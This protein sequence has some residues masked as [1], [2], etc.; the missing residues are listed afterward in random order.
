[1]SLPLG[2]RLGV[3]EVLHKLG[4]GGMG[5]VYKA[6][7][8]RL[9]RLVA[10]KILGAQMAGPE[11]L[12]RFEQE[13]RAA[14]ALNHPNILT[15]YDVGRE[16]EVVYFAMEW[17]EGQTLRQLMASGPLPLARALA[18][19]QQAAEGLAKAHAAGVVHRDLKPENVMVSADGYA[20]IVD[21]GLAKFVQGA[22]SDAATL[23]AGT[24][25]GLVMGSAGYMSPEQARGGAVDYR[26]DQFALGLLIYEMV[27]GVRPFARPTLTQTLAATIDE[28]PEPIERRAPAVSEHLAAVV[29]RC[30][31]KQP[32]ERYESTRDL[33]R[34]LKAILDTQSRGHRVAAPSVAAL[35]VAA[36]AVAAP[37]RV[38]LVAAAAAAVLIVAAV[39]AAVW[40]PAAPAAPE[41]TGHPIVAVQAFQNLS[42]DASQGYFA[43]GMT[44]E[45]RGQLSKVGA[46]RLLSRSAVD[47]Y[48]GDH[49]R[50]VRELGVGSVVEGTVRVEGTRVRIGATLIDAATQ[51]TL[52]SEQYDRDLADV[53]AVQS[54]VALRI[55]Q[56]LHAN[57]SADERAR[58]ERRPTD[59]LEAYQLYLKARQI[60]SASRDGNV[61]SIALMRQAL[62]LDP[63]FALARAAM[64]YRMGFLG[65]GDATWWPNALEEAEAAV[66]T[67]PSLPTAHF[68]LA[69]VYSA[70]GRPAQARMSFLRALEIDPSHTGSMNNL[71]VH[72]WNFGRSD[73]SLHW[74][75]RAFALSDKQGNSFYH[76][77]I[78]LTT[79]DLDALREWL[80]YAERFA[81][82]H[83]RVQLTFATLE[84]LEGRAAEARS[85]VEAARATWPHNEEV[86]MAAADVAFLT[87]R[88]DAPALFE[89]LMHRPELSWTVLQSV[90]LRVAY[91]AARG[92]DAARAAELLAGA[93]RIARQRLE[94]GDESALPPLEIAGVAAVRGERDAAL[95]WLSRAFDAGH[96]DY[97]VL[98]RNPIFAPVSADPRFTALV[99]RMRADV[100]AQQARARERG[101]LDFAP[102]LPQ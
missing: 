62:A 102:L 50:M 6:R 72:E 98:E 90:R 9:D 94:A 54:D 8:T 1:M 12:H 68:A 99:A 64:A 57:L 61:E 73:E 26:S 91:F 20:K 7:D 92:G 15:I 46:L 60:S 43:A 85:R 19:A 67:D 78:P 82:P 100:A 18:I 29:A 93:E 48:A 81:P 47:A 14:S 71:S 95:E 3:Y 96:R 39:G 49:S 42:P 17:V 76:V 51:Q 13:A 86:L 84:A 66:R 40:W 31:A 55:A 33:A 58:I 5:E 16:G 74:A 89:S 83:P 97:H 80:T 34:D 44:E 27:T 63:A 75:R 10:V 88:E 38:R 11:A 36:P 45:I 35:P 32:A 56:A 53:F 52:W 24:A 77:A 21:F 4:E 30:L 101:L 59:N 25:P 41:E 23:A 28:D 79:L 69:S 70:M 65:M 37:S 22:A 87:G 2:T